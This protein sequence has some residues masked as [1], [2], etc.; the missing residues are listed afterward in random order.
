MC[1]DDPP[2]PSG[3]ILKR[4]NGSSWVK[5]LLKVY[6][7]GSWQGKILKRWTGTEWLPVEAFG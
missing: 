3:G 7:S 2:E 4:W 1:F 6:L 5:A